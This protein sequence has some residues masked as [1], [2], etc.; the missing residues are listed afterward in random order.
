MNTQSALPLP[1]PWRS[2]CIPLTAQENRHEAL[3]NRSLQLDAAAAHKVR[4][5]KRAEWATLTLRQ[6]WADESWMRAHLVAAGLRI[7]DNSEPATVPRL[8]SLLRRVGIQG[9][10]FKAATGTDPEGFLSLNPGLP[11]W[12]AVALVLESS[13]RFSAATRAG[14]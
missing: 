11:L 5:L 1:T 14:A 9:P 7:K 8:R 2:L 3:P 6:T 13:G 4:Q 12:A 10:E